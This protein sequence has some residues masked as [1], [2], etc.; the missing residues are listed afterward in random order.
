[1]NVTKIVSI[2][3]FMGSLGLAYVLFNNIHST[4]REQERLLALETET[5]TKLEII[6]EAEKVFWNNTAITRP[7]GIH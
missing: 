4:I 3:L 1:M 7:I 2:I 6:R 5:K